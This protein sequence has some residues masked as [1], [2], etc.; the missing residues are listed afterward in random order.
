[1]SK[2]TE[3]WCRCV[4]RDG[5]SQGS[6]VLDELMTR[7]DAAL[8]WHRL[9]HAGAADACPPAVAAALR[10]A[11][12]ARALEADII[13]RE[14]SR[15]LDAAGDAGIA[16]LAIKGAALAHTHYPERHLRARG[17]SDL[18]I[19]SHDRQR[20]ADV[21]QACGYAP[22][23]AVDGTLVTQQAQW[24]R[25]LGRGLVHTLDVHWQVFNRHA[26]SGVLS[27]EELFERSQRVPS[28]GRHA[29]TPHPVHAL[30]LACVHRVAHHAGVE[31][32]LWLYDIHLLAAGLSE[33][34][35]A[36]LVML[37]TERRVA[38]VCADS[39]HAA[40]RDTGA[41]LPRPIIS[42]LERAPWRDA[43]EPSAAFLHAHRGVDH[44]VSDLGALPDVGARA[45]L[46]WQHVFPRPGYMLQKYSARTRW[47]LPYLYVKRIVEGAPRWFTR[48]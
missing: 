32:L 33:V 14:L 10:R 8:A 34:E 16:V 1:M 19:R 48:S 22:A 31:D 38:A 26:F 23:E 7:R 42:W 29:R 24:E 17:D 27:I 4:I 9:V 30:L 3:E 18:V 25:R 11:A 2:S 41:R 47:L 39:L 13:D 5:L 12:H 45:R 20:L 40:V 44:L 46:L 15:V 21:L 6:P 36:E 35:A 43:A 28:L 37:A